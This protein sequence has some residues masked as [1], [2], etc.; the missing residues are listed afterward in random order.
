VQPFF[1]RPFQV[2]ALHGFA[3]ALCAEIED[4][5]VKALAGGRLLGSIDL[6]SDNVDLVENITLRPTLLKLY[7]P[8]ATIA[9]QS[10]ST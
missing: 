1:G 9:V 3:G 4:P 8:Q 7:E 2:I 5:A 6:L 10:R